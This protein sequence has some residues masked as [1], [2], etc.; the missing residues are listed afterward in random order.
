[1]RYKAGGPRRVYWGVVGVVLESSGKAAELGWTRASISVRNDDY[2]PDE[3]EPCRFWAFAFQGKE[4]WRG[5][6]NTWL[7]AQDVLDTLLIET[8]DFGPDHPLSHERDELRTFFGACEPNIAGAVGYHQ[9]GGEYRIVVDGSDKPI[10]YDERGK[11]RFK[12]NL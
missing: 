7:E 8:V 5:P 3:L 1:M 6:F 4:Q 9:T 2:A 10:L 11:R 12:D